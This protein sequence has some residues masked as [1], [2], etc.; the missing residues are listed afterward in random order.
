MGQSTNDVFPTATRLAILLRARRTC[1]RRRAGSRRRPAREERG[2]SRSVLKTGRTHL[3]DAVPITLGQEFGGY[4]ANVAHAADE[5][6]R[7][8]RTA[9]RAQPRRDGRRHGPERRRRLHL[10][11]NREPRPLYRAAAAAG[12]GSLP[13]HAKHGRRARLFRRAP[14]SRGRSRQDRLRPAPAEHGAARRHRAR[15]SC[16]RSSPD[17]R[18]CRARSTRRCRRW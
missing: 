15:S 10:R 17:R 13:R 4:A 1:W 6:E 7:T 3:Q 18:S 16:R 11:R 2:R 12:G 14:P 8:R 9:L 5:L